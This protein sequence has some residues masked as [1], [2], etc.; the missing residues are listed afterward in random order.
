MNGSMNSSHHSHKGISQF[1]KESAKWPLGGAGGRRAT[2]GFRSS[3]RKVRDGPW[4][5][6]GGGGAGCS[7]NYS[8]SPLRGSRNDVSQ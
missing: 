7:W 3:Q 5:G 4:E 6:L 1:A 8:P 2:R